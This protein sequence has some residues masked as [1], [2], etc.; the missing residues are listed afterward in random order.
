PH[1]TL[2]GEGRGKCTR[3]PRR[4]MNCSQAHDLLQ[5]RLDGEPI[6]DRAALDQHLAQCGECRQLHAAAARLED[7]LRVVPRLSPPAGL[8]ASMVAAA[9]DERGAR[10]LRPLRMVGAAL[11]AGLLLAVVAGWATTHRDEYGWSIAGGLIRYNLPVSPPNTEIEI[12]ER[13]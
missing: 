5:Q 12:I 4:A 13:E 8:G 10:A 1:P 2:S 3:G 11:A 9:L 7:G 6:A